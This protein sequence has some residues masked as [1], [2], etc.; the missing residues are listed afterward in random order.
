MRRSREPGTHAAVSSGRIWRMTTTLG[1]YSASAAALQKYDTTE[2][3][4]PATLQQAALSHRRTAERPHWVNHEGSAWG[5]DGCCGARQALVAQHV[6]P[7]EWA[8]G[9]SQAARGAH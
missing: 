3:A 1:Q 5:D 2:V 6:G 7:A 4:N 9:H 8:S